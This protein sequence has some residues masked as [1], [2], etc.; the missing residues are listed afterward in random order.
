MTRNERNWEKVQRNE[1]VDGEAGSD[2]KR[3][4]DVMSFETYFPL[5]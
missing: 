5:K 2:W 1:N 3:K 4:E